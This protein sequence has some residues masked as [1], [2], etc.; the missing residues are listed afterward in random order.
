MTVEITEEEVQRAVQRY[1]IE[2]VIKTDG[3]S[4]NVF[5]NYDGTWTAEIK[6]KK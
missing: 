3:K 4:I 5:N 1:I 2:E 6:D